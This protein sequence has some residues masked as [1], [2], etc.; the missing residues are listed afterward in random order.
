MVIE[1]S[2]GVPTYNVPTFFRL[3]ELNGNVLED[4]K[5]GRSPECPRG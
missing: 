4:L 5:E 1:R 3:S 2:V